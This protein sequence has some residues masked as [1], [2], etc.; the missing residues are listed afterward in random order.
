[1]R[2]SRACGRRRPRGRRSCLLV[3]RA[4]KTRYTNR[5]LT[6]KNSRFSGSLRGN[7]GADEPGGGPRRTRPLPGRAPRSRAPPPALPGRPPVGPRPLP[8]RRGLLCFRER[9]F[10]P[11]RACGAVPRLPRGVDLGPRR[12][13]ARPPRPSG[14][15]AAGAG[16][17]A[18]GRGAGRGA[19][20]VTRETGAAAPLRTRADAAPRGA[21]ARVPPASVSGGGAEPPRLAR[22]GVSAAPGMR[23]SSRS[24]HAPCGE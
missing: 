7:G 6:S 20:P 18:G 5:R 2:E 12:S 3:S 9:R 14:S 13:E 4:L 17:G 21:D 16:A 24:R 22:P 1:M 15:R 19:P 10:R 8:G 23:P 11:R